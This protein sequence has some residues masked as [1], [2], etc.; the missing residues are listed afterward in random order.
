MKRFS[1]LRFS[2]C[3]TQNDRESKISRL[4]K[5]EIMQCQKELTNLKKDVEPGFMDSDPG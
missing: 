5:R 3:L 2:V 4:F 1:E